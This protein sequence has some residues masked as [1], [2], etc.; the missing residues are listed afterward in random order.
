MG[1]KTVGP[2]LAT[3]VGF[4]EIKRLIPGDSL[5]TKEKKD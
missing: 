1:I 2:K 5:T 3:F 4:I